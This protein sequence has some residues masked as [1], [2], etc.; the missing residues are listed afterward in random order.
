MT[1]T[2]NA[3]AT[4]ATA[5]SATATAATP[6]TAPRVGP[7]PVLWLALMATPWPPGPTPPS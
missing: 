5:A 7:V 1:T 2:T 3:A 6:H 4:A